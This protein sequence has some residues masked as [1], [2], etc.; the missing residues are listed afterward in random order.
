[1]LK[2]LTTYPNISFWNILK[3]TCLL[4]KNFKTF[5]Y[6]YLGPTK[7]CINFQYLLCVRTIRSNES[8]FTM[9]S[10]H[11]GDYYLQLEF[12]THINSDR[13]SSL[14][15]LETFRV[16]FVRNISEKD[17][18]ETQNYIAVLLKPLYNYQTFKIAYHLIIVSRN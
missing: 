14:S 3:Y 7:Y 10:F 12:R 18:N 15:F 6:I 17:L 16:G 8:N 9:W 2:V 1:M 13:V 5:I 11:F 4:W